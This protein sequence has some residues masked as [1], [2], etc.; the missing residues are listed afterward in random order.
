MTARVLPA[1]DPLLKNANLP[2]DPAGKMAANLKGIPQ[3]YVVD[4][5]I[6]PRGIA[7]SDAADGGRDARIE[8]L[9]VGYDAQGNRVNYQ[10]QTL[11]IALKAKQ[12]ESVIANG[13]HARMFLDLPAGP[14]FLRIAVQ[15][16]NAGRAGSLEVPVAVAA[17]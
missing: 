15:D 10:D 12:F 6:D 2:T 1:T 14:G 13:L 8:F 9:L 5:G 11:S 16:L 4:L 3:L 17:K 7:F